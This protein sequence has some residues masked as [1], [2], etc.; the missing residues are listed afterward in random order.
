MILLKKEHLILRDLLSKP[1]K[2]QY[3]Y[4]MSKVDKK[5]LFRVFHEWHVIAL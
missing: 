5:D 4:I 2:K 1:K 3:N